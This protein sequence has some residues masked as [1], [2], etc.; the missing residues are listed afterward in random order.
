MM[1]GKKELLLS[2][3][4]QTELMEETALGVMEHLPSGE[5]IP[6]GTLKEELQGREAIPVAVNIQPA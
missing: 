3:Y 5:R 1:R 6:S 2:T 4:W